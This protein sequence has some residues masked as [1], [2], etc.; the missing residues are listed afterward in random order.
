MYQLILQSHMGLDGIYYQLFFHKHS[1]VLYY[2]IIVY[3]VKKINRQ[4][5]L[6]MFTVH[7]H[8]TPSVTSSFC[9]PHTL[10][11]TDLG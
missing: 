5:S 10:R 11:T 4:G 3:I 6:S 1:S 8:C 7:D 9:T 2:V